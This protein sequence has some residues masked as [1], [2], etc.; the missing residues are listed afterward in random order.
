MPAPE[1]KV[2]EFTILVEEESTLAEEPP[3]VIDQSE[4]CSYEEEE[5][6]WRDERSRRKAARAIYLVQLQPWPELRKMANPPHSGVRPKE[7]KKILGTYR[8]H[9]KRRGI[10]LK[11]IT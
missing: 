5:P 10:K 7:N 9:R 3:P 4:G 6:E 8:H 1:E 2:I 11:E